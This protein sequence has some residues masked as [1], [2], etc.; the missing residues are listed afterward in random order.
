MNS[1]VNSPDVLAAL[2]QKKRRIKKKLQTSR[3]Q[4]TDNVSYL[5]GGKVPQ[6]ADRVQKIA[7]LLIN[8][9][10]IYRGF[11]FCSGVFSGIHSFF[12]PSKRRK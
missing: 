5:T 12:A 1:I 3:T 10:V 11:R 7:R 4:M 9:L 6:T 2:Q 8:G